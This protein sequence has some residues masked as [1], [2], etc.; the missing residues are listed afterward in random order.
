MT[1]PI[2]DTKPTEKLILLVMAILFAPPVALAMYGLSLCRDVSYSPAKPI[3]YQQR[4]INHLEQERDTWRDRAEASDRLRADQDRSL[5]ALLAK[6]SRVVTPVEDQS[7][8]LAEQE[9]T[10]H[11]LRRELKAIEEREL[12][13]DSLGKVD[14]RPEE[15][16]R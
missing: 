10:I 3:D 4:T 12:I 6:F 7:Y 14:M 9:K 15:T 2:H 5:D 13:R 1:A 8:R 16:P 11:L